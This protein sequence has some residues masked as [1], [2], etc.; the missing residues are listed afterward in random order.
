MVGRLVK[1]ASSPINA[2]VLTGTRSND[3]DALIDC[4]EHQQPVGIVFSPNLGQTEFDEANLLAEIYSLRMPLSV[5]IPLFELVTAEGVSLTELA[6]RLNNAIKKSTGKQAT[7]SQSRLSA[8]KAKIPARRLTVHQYLT[9]CEA[10]GKDPVDT[11]NKLTTA[12]QRTATEKGFC[13]I[14]SQAIKLV[15]MTAPRR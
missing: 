11:F 5:H 8:L 3:G 15:E 9:I 4:P 13:E 6:T 14:I 2:G 7:W 12:G 1:V 10:V